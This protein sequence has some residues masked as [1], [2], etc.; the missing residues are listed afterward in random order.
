MAEPDAEVFALR[1]RLQRALS[2]HA[3]LYQQVSGV[4]G[5]AEGVRHG[6]CLLS[7]VHD[8]RHWYLL[9]MLTE[10]QWCSLM[11]AL[12]STARA[13]QARVHAC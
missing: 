9:L 11:S 12:V 1:L 5:S 13:W 6:T 4:V 2:D 10:V 7:C 3:D 8:V